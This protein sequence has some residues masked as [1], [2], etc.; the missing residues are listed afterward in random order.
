MPGCL[1][2]LRVSVVADGPAALV[3]SDRI[4]ACAFTSLRCAS[5]LLLLPLGLQTELS[6]L[7][8][9]LPPQLFHLPLGVRHDLLGLLPLLLF[10]LTDLFFDLFFKLPFLQV[11]ES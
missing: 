6:D 5:E 4:P 8:V 10:Q 7:S 2:T 1:R 9:R 11:Q 3:D